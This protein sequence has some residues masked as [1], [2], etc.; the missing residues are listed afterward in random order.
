MSF[1]NLCV[2]IVISIICLIVS[3]AF[4]WFINLTS[5]DDA[6]GYFLTLCISDVIIAILI[7][8]LLVQHG[9]I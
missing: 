7:I 4:S 9:V 1:V 5:N 6:E 3:I 8:V 2:G